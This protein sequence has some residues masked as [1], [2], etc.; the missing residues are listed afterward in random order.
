MNQKIYGPKQTVSGLTKWLGGS[1]RQGLLLYIYIFFKTL[2]YFI[3]LMLIEFSE[4]SDKNVCHYSKRAW[5]CHL[6]CK[7]SGCSHRPARHRWE[8]ESLNSAQFI[9]QWLIR[10][11]EFADVSEFLLHLGKKHYCQFRLICEKLDSYSV[12][13]LLKVLS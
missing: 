4:F 8:T 10:F 6:L 7:T 3:A 13:M 1:S 11:P 5:T 2:C 12:F 9:L